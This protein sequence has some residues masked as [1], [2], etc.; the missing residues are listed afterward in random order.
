MNSCGRF[1]TSVVHPAGFTLA[2]SIPMV[3]GFF[4]V[5]R[6]HPL[7]RSPHLIGHLLVVGPG[8]ISTIQAAV[9]QA[10]DGDSILVKTGNYSGFSIV[11]KDLR[12][13]ADHGATVNVVGQVSVTQLAVGKT[14]LLTGLEIRWDNS[15]HPETGA[16]TASN[17]LGHLRLQECTILGTG[18]T[19]YG[20]SGVSL[21]GSRD[22]C[23][24][25]C[26]VEAGQYTILPDGSPG[27]TAVGSAVA[28]YDSTLR[29]GMGGLGACGMAGQP[30]GPG[31]PGGAAYAQNE[32]NPSF[33]FS[34]GSSLYGGAG[35][36]GGY[37][38]CDCSSPGSA[39]GTGG[40]GG[41]CVE[42]TGSSPDSVSV[43]TLDPSLYPGPGGL[44]GYGGTESACPMGQPDGAHGQQGPQF[45][46][47]G[48]QLQQLSG[49]SRK[50][51]TLRAVRANAPAPV[52]CYGV[53]G[54]TYQV[55]LSPA[56]DFTYLPSMHGV[57]LVQ[58]SSA[59]LVASGTVPSSGLFIPMIPLPP[60]DGADCL[61]LYLQA[62]VRDPSG[63]RFVCAQM[64][65]LE[66]DP[67]F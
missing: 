1:I 28:I 11:N 64:T 29:G 22:V 24:A 39:G 58:M 52:Y 31:G 67:A 7:G 40:V 65:L 27:I 18:I 34:S 42:Q 53:P 47:P 19:G 9:D 43:A 33:V 26:D 25:A 2:L 14:V 20:E 32:S 23:F 35:G 10:V 16:L 3:V 63:Q 66:L 5:P 41:P 55:F 44:G 4:M 59:Q 57:S 8:H 50:F 38:T 37:C 62:Y 46:V 13:V 36:V 12:V 56:L 54:D 48:Q 51:Q 30:G 60:L 61:P 6:Q 21:E 15:Q 49:N 45:I 17:N